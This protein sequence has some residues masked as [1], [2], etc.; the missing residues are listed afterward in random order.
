MHLQSWNPVVALAEGSAC[1]MLASLVA[2]NQAVVR[3]SIPGSDRYAG[4][5]GPE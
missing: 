3:R 1:L 2:K 4:V 5:A